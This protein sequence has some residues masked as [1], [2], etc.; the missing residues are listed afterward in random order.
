MYT[1]YGTT[2][3]TEIS[4]LQL[5]NI[6]SFMVRIRSNHLVHLHPCSL[7]NTKSSWLLWNGAISQE[8]LFNIPPEKRTG[9]ELVL[10]SASLFLKDCSRHSASLP[11]LYARLPYNAGSRPTELLW[12]Q[13]PSQLEE[14]RNL[15]ATR[16]SLGFLENLLLSQH[17]ITCL[18]TS[19]CR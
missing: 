11:R 19:T 16:T 9:W 12:P 6:N 14:E 8:F 3:R 2:P 13:F 1:A 7:S 15:Q 10:I 4:T 5:R 17:F 18:F